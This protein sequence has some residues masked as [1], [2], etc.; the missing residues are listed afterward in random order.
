[1]APKTPSTG[2]KIPTGTKTRPKRAQTPVRV[3]LQPVSVETNNKPHQPDTPK[4][5]KSSSNVPAIMV[6]SAPA[7]QT[8]LS[9][10]VTVAASTQSSNL[11][12]TAS[13]AST[14]TTASSAASSTAATL[15]SRPSAGTNDPEEAARVLAEKRR[16]ARE[17]RER[18]EQER[19]EQEKRK[20][21]PD[22]TSSFL[23]VFFMSVMHLDSHHCSRSASAS[24]LDACSHHHPHRDSSERWRGGVSASTPDITQRQRRRNSTLLDKKKKEKKDKERENE[25]EKVLKKL[26]IPTRS[27]PEFSSTPKP[28]NR[29]PSPV[30]PKSKL[31][32][33]LPSNGSQDPS[34]G[35]KIPTG[36]KTR[37][38]RAQTPVRVQLQPVSVETNNKPHQPDTP[39][40]TK[41][42]SN[43]PAIMVSSARGRPQTSLVHQSQWL[44]L[45]NLKPT[46][47]CLAASTPTTA[48]SAAS[49]TAAIWLP[50]PSAGTN[51]PEEAA[52]V[53]AEKRETGPGATGERGAGAPGAREEGTVQ[54]DSGWN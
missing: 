28:Q 39:K 6:S 1:M 18:E 29:P 11:Q 53:L 26:P 24:P 23:P 25:K 34:T 14:P 40:E 17:Q 22:L 7:T 52:R 42:S 16:Q 38:K 50:R 15:A 35:K 31:F 33:P 19:L 8:S 5:T 46:A 41:S 49:S 37:P 43:V 13:A 32:V 48:S 45:L 54:S 47:D 10:P 30:A 9:A 36:T 4:E 27:R 20:R 12:L 3:Q 44:P 2:K 21:G 51:D